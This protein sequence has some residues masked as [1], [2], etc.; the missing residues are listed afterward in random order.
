MTRR[1]LVLRPEPGAS[2]TVRAAEALG[3]QA[4]R[5]PLFTTS[6]CEWLPADPAILDAV[7]MTS[8]NAAR[9][10]GG[11]LAPLFHLPL[12]AVGA[13]TAQAARA[14]GF[15]DVRAG[16]K[17]A[18]A[19]VALAAEQGMGRLL[20]LA[21]RDYHDAR[22]PG[23]TIERRIV[24]RADR[25]E[26]LPRPALAALELGAVALV[27]S[28]RAGR[29]FADLVD[30][31]MLVRSAIRIAAISPAAMNGAGRGWLCAITADVP[32]DLALLAAAA[33]LCE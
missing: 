8:A 6:A 12:Y 7:L 3:W 11:G 19:I 16:D 21:G 17:D 2:A 1:L 28:P 26:R 27:H 25:V 10:G 14:V 31:A 23:V 30:E 5:A 22:H 33:R 18:S 13:A 9:L 24:Y 29:L 20:H 4:A 32:N 15:A